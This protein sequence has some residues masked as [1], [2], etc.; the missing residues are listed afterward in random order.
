MTAT[1]VPVIDE[2]ACLALLVQL[3]RIKSYTETAGELQITQLLADKMQ[4]LG[5]DADVHHFA[6]GARQNA[7]GRWQGSDPAGG[8]SKTLLFNGHL[9][10]N[11]VGEG[12]TVDPWEGKVDD[13]FVYGI[14]VSNMKAG[15]AAYFCAVQTL[16]AG[17]G[18]VG[19][20]AAIWQGRMDA[21]CFVN[22]EP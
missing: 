19:T 12:W 3:I 4:D 6:D 7:I 1:T 18:G 21:D 14:G 8:T 13:D 9:D 15:C 5:L 16:K 22:C 10:T 2:D 11:P 20:V 17:G